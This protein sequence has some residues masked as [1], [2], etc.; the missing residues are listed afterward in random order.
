MVNVRVVHR[1]VVEVSSE[2]LV[3]FVFQDSRPPKKVLG[4]IDWFLNSLISK[5]IRDAKLRLDFGELNLVATQHRV[6]APKLLLIGM[7]R[8][9]DFTLDMAKKVFLDIPSTISGLGV[10]N[11]AFV[12]PDD[13]VEG[14]SNAISN[15]AVTGIINGVKKGSIKKELWFS[16]VV[17]EAK[18]A[19]TMR[20]KLKESLTPI[21]EANLMAS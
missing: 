3:A 14:E 2:L 20:A 18:T 7:G 8:K 12:S 13:V 4:E 15:E 16:V 9:K 5:M 1:S 17:S 11:V 21:Q 10:T 19:E 6:V